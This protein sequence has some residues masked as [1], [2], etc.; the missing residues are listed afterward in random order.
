MTLWDDSPEVLALDW[1]AWNVAHI[2]KHGVT[3]TEVEEAIEGDTVARASYKRRW[4][5]LGATHVGRV[6]AIVIGQSPAQPGLYYVF[7][8]RPADRSE[9]RLFRLMKENDDAG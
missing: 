4:L 6:L 8:A 5:V 9:R 3:R 1:D 7:S 2:A